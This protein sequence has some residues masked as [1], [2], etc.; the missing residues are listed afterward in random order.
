M[1]SN[2]FNSLSMI[3]F[4]AVSTPAISEAQ[5]SIGVRAQGLAGAFV[6]VADDATA[7]YWNPS[8]L[9]TGA[10]VS[11][12]LDYGQ[13][14]LG[15]DGGPLLAAPA[16]RQTAGI[17]AFS[18]PPVGFAYYRIVSF[19]AGPREPVV[20]GVSD[21]EDVRRSVHALTTSTVGVALLQSVG[22]YLVVGATLKLMRGAAAD[23]VS[24]AFGA[25]EALDDAEALPVHRETKGDVDLSAMSAIGH[26]RLGVVAHNLTT[27]SFALADAATE[28]VE[29]QRQVRIGGGWGSGWPGLSRVVVAVDA[30]VTTRMTPDGDRRDL[31]AGTETW[32]MRQRLGVRAG[33]RR[34]TV[35]AARS[36]V[37]AGVSASVMPGM[38][39]EG[40]VARGQQDERS[41]SVGA[42]FTF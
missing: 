3:V 6:G 2:R 40:H 5:A 32:W 13:S 20:L 10:F 21:R 11:F 29:L 12:V 33:V 42:R 41:W 23:G 38:F 36:V 30:D 34:S 9:A 4:L 17:V 35:G 16:G 7:V 18:A 19:A 14:E 27:P 24:T 1:F 26:L 25:D 15:P 37:A 31:A 39:L 28:V 8:G 22:Q